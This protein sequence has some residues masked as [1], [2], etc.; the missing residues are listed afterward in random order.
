MSKPESDTAERRVMPEPWFRGGSTSARCISEFA[1]PTREVLRVAR[2]EIGERQLGPFVLPP[3]QR[4]PAWTREQQ[5]RLIESLW[6]GLPIG[7]YVWN[8]TTLDDPCDGWLLDGQQRVT[9]IL[10]YVAGDFPVLGW[11]YPDLPRVDQR[12]FDMMPVGAIQTGY[13]DPDQCRDV[14]DRLAYG[15]TP[16]EMSVA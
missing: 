7:S 13:R 4:P 5:I 9:A 2:K 15:G 8:E 6:G 11:R 1:R 16:H 14:Y 3:F 10:A 12:R